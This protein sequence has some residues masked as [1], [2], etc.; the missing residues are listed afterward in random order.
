MTFLLETYTLAVEF[1]RPALT[2]IIVVALLDIL[3][4]GLLAGGWGS[5]FRN[6][7]RAI[8]SALGV[9][10]VVALIALVLLPAATHASWANLHGAV[11]YLGLIILAGGLGLAA[12]AAV[13]PPLQY[14]LGMG[15]RSTLRG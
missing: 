12:A 9:G 14:M 7:G 13:F 15:R 1:L 11:D 4:L 8:G 2:G 3:L 5:S 6:L 10:V